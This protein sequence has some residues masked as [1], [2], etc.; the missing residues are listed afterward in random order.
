M[1]KPTQ[2]HDKTDISSNIIDKILA[3]I[4][5]FGLYWAG[6]II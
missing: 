6:Q 4:I 2:C 1:T 5:G 3:L